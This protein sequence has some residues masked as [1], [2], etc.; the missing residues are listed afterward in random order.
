VVPHL[1]DWCLVHLVAE[2]ALERVAVEHWNPD[3]MARAAG[4][5]ATL[6]LDPDVTGGAAA[7]VASGRP[8]RAEAAGSP[9]PD[10]PEDVRALRAL[11]ARSWLLLPLRV[12]GRTRAVVTLAYADSTRHYHA[13]DQALAEDLAARAA[14]ALDNALLFEEVE[15]AV[16]AREDTLSIVSHDLKN[17]MSALLLGMQRLTRL[18]DEARR[19]QADALLAKLE[20]TVRG[21]NRLIDGLLDLARLEAGRLQLERRREPAGAVLA[22]ALEPLEPLA[23]EKGLRLALEAPASLPEVE[24]DPDRMAQVIS[25][26]VG[27]AIKFTPEGGRVRVIAERDPAGLRFAVADDGPGIPAEQLRHLFDRY[28]QPPGG[29]RRGHGLG[30][31]I[32][33]GLVEA[34]GGRVWV[35]SEVGAGSTFFFTV[36]LSG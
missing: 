19:P 18:A 4:L 36:P 31:F 35:E 5:P 15:H 10:E 9:E 3:A 28:W 25:N 26:L 7:V 32:V 30:L 33:K 8:L 12:R 21:M 13:L 20:R 17:P 6:P 14:M 1:A 2:R 11:G 29:A 16:R 22:R 23:S 34:H 27:N 24:W